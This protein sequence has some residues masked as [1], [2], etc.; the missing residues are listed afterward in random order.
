MGGKRGRLITAADKQEALTL[1]QE[2]RK[3]GCRIKPACELLELDMRT[4]QRWIKEDDLDDKRHGPLTAPANKLTEAERA[5]ILEVANSPEYCSQPPSQIIP[6]LADKSIYIA[7]ESSFYRTLKQENMLQHRSA[8]RPKK[9][10][11]P[12]ELCAIRPN[13]L[14]SWDISY[15]MSNIR[16]KY[17]YLYLFMDIFS[18][19]IVGFDVFDS[20][21]AEYAANVVNNSYLIEGLQAG[22]VILHSDNGG[23]MKGST[24][25]ATLQ[26]LGIIPSFSRPSVS[27][28][29]PYSESL[30]KTLKYCPQYP[31]KPFAS[32][33]DAK[34]WVLTF[35]HW[36]NHVHQHSGINFVTP[37]AR[38]QLRDKS[39]LENRTLVYEQAK[40]KNPNR[41]SKQV[42]NW[43]YINEVYLNK[44]CTSKQAA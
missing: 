40:N 21:S 20:E 26:K 24:M 35:V 10:K 15:L 11:K 37:N 22:D 25:L 36:Y 8:A 44:K 34:T 30:F 12:N 41:W 7:S 29:N 4:L 13:Q 1:I 23:P 19:K 31:D 2:A 5:R 16:G 3:A 9:H 17:F 32:I 42:R 43:R 38:H 39:I 6:N 28:D 33:K 18:R 14:W 27:D